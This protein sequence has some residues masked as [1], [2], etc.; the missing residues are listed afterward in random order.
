MKKIICIQLLLSLATSVIF[1]GANN[2]IELY[3]SKIMKTDNQ[4]NIK[5]FTTSADTLIDNF[6]SSKKVKIQ[7]IPAE[8]NNEFVFKKNIL[9]H[10][11]SKL[12]KEN[13]D[14]KTKQS[15]SQDITMSI[16]EEFAQRI[17]CLRIFERNDSLIKAVNEKKISHKSRTNS[18]F[19]EIS[20]NKR[21]LL[22]DTN[23]Y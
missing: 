2:K 8:M 1:C 4:K 6:F 20:A 12:S 19:P 21:Y 18:S 9:L 14:E 16:F 11:L 7:D 5:K 22:E 10:K 15:R 13:I 23:S 3:K 17:K